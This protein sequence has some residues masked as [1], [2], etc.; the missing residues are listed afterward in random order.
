M[1]RA[2]IEPILID[3]S[4]RPFL[5]CDCLAPADSREAQDNDDI[6]CNEHGDT[7]TQVGQRTPNIS[8]TVGCICYRQPSIGCEIACPI[9]QGITPT[10]NDEKPADAIGLRLGTFKLLSQPR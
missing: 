9:K 3:E 10:R 2:R 7:A 6:K 8:G 1:Q 5:G 4:L